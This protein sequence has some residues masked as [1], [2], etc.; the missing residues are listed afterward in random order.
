VKSNLRNLTAF[1]LVGVAAVTLGVA[2]ALA[3]GGHTP[4]TI[5][6]KPGTPAEQTLVVDDDSVKLAGHL[7]HGDTLGPCGTETTPTDTTPTDTTPTE[8]TPTETTPTE[9][10]P[11]TPIP[12]T[13]TQ[14][15]CPAGEGPYDGKDGDENEPG[16]NDECCP[17]SNNNQVCDYKET[18]PTP[19]KQGDVNTLSNPQGTGS[20]ATSAAPASTPATKAFAVKK[21]KAAKKAAAVK[22]VRSTGAKLT[23]D[24]KVD[25]CKAENG[26]FECQP[27]GPGTPT[28]T[29]VPGRG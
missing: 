17:D 23:G 1:A 24:P 14:P 13:P 11:T 5:C 7:G 29:V 6:H 16:H 18:T 10:T 15:R 28:I 20:T 4:V 2:A 3:G 27:G 22:K 8:T 21:A 26:L 19:A 25:R 9:T 12:T